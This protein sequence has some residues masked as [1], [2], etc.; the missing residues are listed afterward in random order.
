MPEMG[1]AAGA[2]EGT[3]MFPYGEEEFDDG[4]SEGHH[5]F[6][7]RASKASGRHNRH[8]S[9]ISIIGKTEFDDRDRNKLRGHELKQL[10][11]DIDGLIVKKTA[12]IKESQSSSQQSGFSLTGGLN[13]QQKDKEHKLK[14]S[15]TTNK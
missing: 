12:E 1:G 5:S 4:R 15:K 9:E 7:S 8:E 11:V 6:T 13:S 10:K 14:A 3:E 2:G